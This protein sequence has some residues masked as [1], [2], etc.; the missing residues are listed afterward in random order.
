ML[1]VRLHRRRTASAV[2]ALF[3]AL[4]VIATPMADSDRAP[5][6]RADSTHDTSARDASLSFAMSVVAS[7]SRRLL[8]AIDAPASF[9][10]GSQSVA[11][12]LLGWAAVCLA[13]WVVF[14]CAGLTRRGRAPPLVR[15]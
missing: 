7:P 4:L 14:L 11:L 5:S 8:S 2:L 15:A 6:T 13:A 12:A 3:V 1:F 9:I 10:S